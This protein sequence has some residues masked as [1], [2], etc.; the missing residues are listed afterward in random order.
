MTLKPLLLAATMAAF[1]LP[2]L[3]DSRI[4]METYSPNAVY[5]IYTR[6][7]RAVL[8]QLEADEKLDGNAT[9]LGMGDAN[10]WNV[11]VRGNNIVFKPTAS[12]PATNMLIVTNKRTYAFDLKVAP[13]NQASTYIMRFRYP[14][15]DAA[16]QLAQE[17]R[18]QRALNALAQSDGAKAQMLNANYWAYGDKDLA[19]SAA[20]D[21]GRFTYFEFDNG[22]PMPTI[23]RVNPDRSE[24]LVNSHIEGKNLIVHETAARFVLRYGKSVLGI[25]NRGYLKAGTF[26]H[27]GTDSNQTVR[28]L[29]GQVE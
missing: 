21:N 15:S 26:N 29:K 14:D 9:A 10:A 5:N 12:S 4:R 6:P 8:V 23:Y 27:T 19:P 3:A 20:Y 16:R 24:S 25:E 28:L 22:R 2:A 7:G 1:S 17:S 11:G 18:R 13:R